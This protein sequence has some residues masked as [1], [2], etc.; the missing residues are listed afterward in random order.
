ME[1]ALEKNELE[2]NSNIN[3][4]LSQRDKSGELEIISEEKNI[5]GSEE[6]T[7]NKGFKK[8]GTSNKTNTE[9]EKENKMLN[10][11]PKFLFEN[12]DNLLPEEKNE[13]DNGDL[14][15]YLSDDN[16]KKEIRTYTNL[17]EININK[18][19]LSKSYNEIK[20][21]QLNKENMDNNNNYKIE[22]PLSNR[23]NLSMKLKEDKEKDRNKALSSKKG[24]L[25]IL[26][27]LT[28][29]KKEKEEIEKKKEELIET[30]NKA[31]NDTDRTLHIKNFEENKENIQSNNNNIITF[32]KNE[33]NNNDN[34]EKEINDKINL[35]ENI[36]NNENN[37]NIIEENKET[38][39][40]M[41]F[42]DKEKEREEE[43]E[44]EI[45]KEK[46]KEKEERES[47]KENIQ[48]NNNI[49][50]SSNRS[51]NE[52]NNNLII[53][54]ENISKKIPIKNKS[55]LYIKNSRK[56]LKK[57]INDSTSK[58]LTKNS[59]SI[60]REKPKIN[61]TLEQ[62]KILKQKRNQ[63]NPQSITRYKSFK[64]NYTNTNKNKNKKNNIIK[65]PQAPSEFREA[66]N[67]QEN[68]DTV[69]IYKKRQM[70]KSPRGKIYAPKKA[71]NPRGSSL[72]K[73]N[74]NSLVGKSNININNVNYI[75]NINTIIKNRNFNDNDTFNEN[76]H[77]DDLVKLNNSLNVHMNKNYNN[78]VIDNYT[79]YNKNDF[80]YNFIRN[81][82]SN[83]VNNQSYKKGL[84]GSKMN[85]NLK[86]RNKMAN[87]IEEDEFSNENININNYNKNSFKNNSSK[88]FI[89]NR[90]TPD[91]NYP[92]KEP[93]HKTG[94]NSNSQRVLK[95]SKNIPSIYQNKYCQNNNLSERYYI[96]NKSNQDISDFNNDIID[97]ES[98]NNTNRYN[99]IS[100]NIED[101]MIFEEKFSDIIYF[102]KNRK[103]ARNQCFDFWNYFYNCSL[104]ERIEKIFKTE[105]NIEIAKLSINLELI[106]VMVCYEFSFD[107][108]ILNKANNLLLE[109]LELSHRNLMIIC[110]NILT[111]I[112]P[113]NQKNI[114]VLKLNNLVQK[115]KKSLSQNYPN[116]SHIE[117]IQI[118][119]SELSQHLQN[120]FSLYETEYSPLI[121]SLF[122]KINQKTYSE[123]NDFFLEYI[124]KIENKESSI[125][126]PVLMSSNPNFISFR[127]PYIHTERI[128]PYT[129]ILDLNDTIV[130]FQQTNNSQ[131]ILRLRPFL[132]EFLD[133]I[134]IYY[135]LILFTTS[136]EYFSKPIINAIEENK[137]YF[138]FVF[139]R[140]YA[141]IV[142][143]D[144]VKDLTRVGR[145]LDSTIIVDNMPQNFRLQKENGI[146]IKPFYAQ[147]PND[148]TL[149]ELMVILIEIAKS[150][151]DVR[152]GLAQYRNDIV[153]KITSNISEYNI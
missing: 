49:S 104:F 87:N 131:G 135:E 137:K 150:G 39:M 42:E 17:N 89:L 59:F 61:I 51:S 121:Y 36:N 20:D 31:R 139:Y 57:P 41:E 136:T 22:L 91:K 118:N 77:E 8:S 6:N 62:S 107:I 13:N 1:L 48:N 120:L 152:E 92:S 69:T 75:N 71:V 44:N 146:H 111:K 70:S 100:I 127:P 149:I 133:E 76:Y 144:F 82:N 142:G 80:N 14:M 32:D 93:L 99:S 141:I 26:E 38:N 18:N 40:K 94:L 101:L 66:K 125:L 21:A 23:L 123:I 130:N 81:Y 109:I 97:T 143:N 74:D 16:E 145:A 147:D 15:N 50:I 19:K 140:E 85:N 53:N 27:L 98:S 9:K 67:I 116:L 56:F 63:E 33:I 7:N 84:I 115:S 95:K 3:N 79:N 64:N 124:L 128:K 24:A 60:S 78:F 34:I 10:Y 108:N 103:E 12:E 54:D 86:V 68:F 11:S 45:D 58:F 30:F 117:L 35:D 88:G 55:K 29:K 5:N 90:L 106:S 119:S 110:E 126:A 47:Q 37:D 122:K 65:K 148:N 4:I 96:Y 2:N 102:I 132:I 73:L 114:W 52:V 113:E 151:I 28:S 153:Q 25:K 72:N 105:N 83:F 46:E 43:K 138:D 112:I 129:L 134:S